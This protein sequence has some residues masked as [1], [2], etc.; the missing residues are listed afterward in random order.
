MTSMLRELLTKSF[1]FTNEATM[2]LYNIMNVSVCASYFCVL[3]PRSHSKLYSTMVA[4]CLILC[5][6]QLCQRNSHSTVVLNS[7]TALGTECGSNGNTGV[8]GNANSSV[9]V[10]QHC[11]YTCGD[12]VTVHVK[13][14][15]ELMST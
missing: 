4:N 13:N 3:Q 6:G 14:Y 8:L 7:D 10:V 11:V 15:L 12:K 2:S 9:E 5:T 1:S